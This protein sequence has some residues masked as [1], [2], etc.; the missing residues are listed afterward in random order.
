MS[1]MT[2]LAVIFGSL[3]VVSPASADS[4]DCSQ[5]TPT[6]GRVTTSHDGD[7]IHVTA[8]FWLSDYQLAQ[9][10]CSAEYLE[11]TLGSDFGQC[12]I[13]GVRSVHRVASSH[14]KPTTSLFIC[15]LKST[16]IN[17]LQ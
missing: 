11:L 2:A 14:T 8:S 9:L 6:Q 12:N 5:Y 16:S 15:N 4:G 7:F 10:Q 3:T 1:L 17:P 13:A